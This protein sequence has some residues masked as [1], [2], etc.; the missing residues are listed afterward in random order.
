MASATQTDDL[1]SGPRAVLLEDRGILRLSGPDLPDFLQR[2]LTNAMPAGDG[3]AIYSALLT[4]Q[5]KFLFDFILVRDKDDILMDTERS[6]L[7]DLLK[8]L[9]LYKL[10]AKID[11]TDETEGHAVI[12]LL[13]ESPDPEGGFVYPDPRQDAMGRRAILPAASAEK[14]V[15]DAGYTLAGMDA[16]AKRRLEVGLP[17][18]PYDVVPEK[19]FPLEANFDEMHAIDFKKGCFVGQEVTSRSKRRGN[20]RKRLVTCRVEGALPQ[21]ETPV[22]KGEREVGTVFSGAG[23][24]V[25]ALLRLDAL[26]ADLMAGDSKLMPELQPWLDLGETTHVE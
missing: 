25:I 11:L 15:S 26:D 8:R 19:T 22:R 2:L 12:A 1:Q 10:R 5:G 4:P 23:E 6:R 20:V 3:E 7:P 13:D 21:P 18:A 16:Y 24:R 17:E 14:S 9:K